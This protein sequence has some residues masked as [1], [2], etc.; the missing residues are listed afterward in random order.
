M[1]LIIHWRPRTTPWHFKQAA[2]V[3][4]QPWRYA[5]AASMTMISAII[6]VYLLFSPLGLVGGLGSEFWWYSGLCMLLNLVLCAWSLKRTPRMR[7]A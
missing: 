2:R 6:V 3:D 5:P 1:L 4:M 7:T